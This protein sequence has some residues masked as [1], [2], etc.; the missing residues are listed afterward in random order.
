MRWSLAA[1]M[2]TGLFGRAGAESVDD[3]L[4]PREI[5]VGEAM[6]GG[7]TGATGVGMNP[8]GLPLNREFVFEGGFGYRPTDSASLVSVSACDSTNPMPGCFFYSYAGA[9]P[10]LDGGM[11]GKRRGHVGGIALSR[12]FVPRVLVGMTTKYY[13]FESNMTGERNAHGVTF[14]LGATLRVTQMVNLGVVGQNLWASDENPEFPRTL[15]GGLMA[16]PIPSLAMTFDMRWKLDGEETSARFGGGI[17]WFL[18]TRNNGYPIRLGAIRDN[19]SKANYVSGGLGF[20]TMK[21]GVDV[22]A[23]RQFDGGDETLVIASMRFWHARMP[24]PSLDGQPN[25]FDQ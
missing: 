5:A 1:V 7:A 6:R 24:A 18:R 17:E 12:Q 23:R 4:G 14:D 9:N 25:A 2:L 11:T 20:A 21:W 3:M 19:N 16:R 22:G 8:A 10:E 15:G 13:D